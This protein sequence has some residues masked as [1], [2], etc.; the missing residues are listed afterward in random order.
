MSLATAA[1]IAYR[2]IMGQPLAP[3]QTVEDW[4]AVLHSV[5]HALS[6]ACPLYSTTEDGTLAQI[7]HVDLVQ[8]RFEHGGAMLRLANGTVRRRL[9]VSRN[10]LH[11]AV[12]ILK[13]IG[14]RFHPK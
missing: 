12:T 6:N 14:A 3:S 9:T 5:A 11:A 1:A 7:S 4:N 10:D 8:A 13:R 2:D